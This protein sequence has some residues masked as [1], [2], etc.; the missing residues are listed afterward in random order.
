[1]KAIAAVGG[2]LG[3]TAAL[4]GLGVALNIFQLK[5]DPVYRDIR[6]EGI[7]HGYGAVTARQEL[8]VRLMLDYE[9]AQTDGQKK[10]IILRMRQE[11][12]M[13]R[14]NQVPSQVNSFLATH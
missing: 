13:L 4:I 7:Q 2:I 8:L 9:T 3:G 11:A 5:M 14:G 1:M 6:T 12:A 10:A